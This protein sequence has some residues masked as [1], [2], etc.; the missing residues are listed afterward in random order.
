[1]SES[2]EL[3]V[4]LERERYDIII[5]CAQERRYELKYDYLYERTIKSTERV[6]KIKA[7]K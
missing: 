1:M 3:E 2:V 4:I 5:N 7:K 6:S